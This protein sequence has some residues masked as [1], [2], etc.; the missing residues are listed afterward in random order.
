MV[1]VDRA[2]QGEWLSWSRMSD[3]ETSAPPVIVGGDGPY[4]IDQDGRRLL[5][6]VSGLFTTQIGYSHGARLG[7]AAARQL[8]QLGFYPNWSATHP[9][10]LALTER[11]L[12]LA[13]EGFTRLF[14]TSGGSESV[15]SAWKLARQ[16][17]LAKGQPA[18]RKIIARRGAYHGCSLGALALTGIPMARAPFEPLMG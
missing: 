4:A 16:H 9:A 1:Y 2:A 5:D 17:H 6:C 12:S 15:E 8:E 7:Q 3:F 18:R 11:I 10:A 13:P 14:L